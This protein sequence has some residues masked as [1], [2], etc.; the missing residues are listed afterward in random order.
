MAKSISDIRFGIAHVI[1]RI[2]LDVVSP[3]RKNSATLRVVRMR[4]QFRAAYVRDI[5]HEAARVIAKSEGGVIRISHRDQFVARVIC[6][7]GNC[8]QAVAEGKHHAEE[9][10]GHRNHASGRIGN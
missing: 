7:S 5:R 1:E 8:A 9:V 6:I 3:G 2:T 10:G 4:F